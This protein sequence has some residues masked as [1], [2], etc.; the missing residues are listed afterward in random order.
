[1]KL[2]LKFCFA[3]FI[4]GTIFVACGSGQQTGRSNGVGDAGGSVSG[5]GAHGTTGTAGAGNSMSGG[6]GSDVGGS[7]VGSNGAGNPSGT[8]GGPS[9]GGTTSK[10][11]LIPLD[12]YLMLDS[13]GSMSEQTGAM[14]AGPTKW[15]GITQALSA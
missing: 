11:E 1:M 2:Q 5:A 15:S 8:G 10:A 9:C 3:T 7:F 13:S 12:I 14:S 6:T 4:L